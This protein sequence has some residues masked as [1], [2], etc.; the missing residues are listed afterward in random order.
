M[1]TFLIIG[2]LFV[3]FA[4]EITHAFVEQEQPDTGLLGTVDEVWPNHNPDERQML[5]NQLR[6]DREIRAL[7]N[8]W[9]HERPRKAAVVDELLE[10]SDRL[11][12]QPYQDAEQALEDEKTEMLCRLVRIRGR[13]W[14]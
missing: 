8:W 1:I 3:W 4:Y 6:D 9:K 2:S 10:Q 12:Y 11:G 14:T 7:Y 5:E 13:L